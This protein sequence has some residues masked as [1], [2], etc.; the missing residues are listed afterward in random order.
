MSIL[1]MS[2]DESPEVEVVVETTTTQLVP[3]VPT[4]EVIPATMSEKETLAFTQNVR[5]HVI[6]QLM[7]DGKVP[8]D[9]SDKIL[10]NNMLDGMDRAALTKMKIEAEAETTNQLADAARSITKLLN[11]VEHDVY[12]ASNPVQRTL[13]EIPNDCIILVESK[14]VVGELDSSYREE[15]IEEFKQ[16]VDNLPD[17]ESE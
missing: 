13:P 4:P 6:G 16:R 5:L 12:T 15:T 14:L 2:D 17:T 3:T 10:L 1:E 11:T 7:S 8:E 9:K